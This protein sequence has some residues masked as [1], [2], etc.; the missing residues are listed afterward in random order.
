MDVGILIE[1]ARQ[2]PYNLILATFERHPRR[3]NKI[4]FVPKDKVQAVDRK[5]VLS[6]LL[7]AVAVSDAAAVAAVALLLLL[8]DCFSVPLASHFEGVTLKSVHFV[9]LSPLA[10]LA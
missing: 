3:G 4:S 9:W 6:M 1:K 5:Y 2:M 8:L 7:F 10:Q